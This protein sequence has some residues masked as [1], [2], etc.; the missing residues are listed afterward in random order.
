MLRMLRS[1][2]SWENAWRIRIVALGFIVL[3]V[4]IGSQILVNAVAASSDTTV[5]T[6]KVTAY[7]AVRRMTDGNWTHVGACA[8]AHAQFPL[9]TVLALYNADGTFVRQCTVE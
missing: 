8:V 2:L 3:S 6:L 5:T 9:G 4:G 1:A 7:T